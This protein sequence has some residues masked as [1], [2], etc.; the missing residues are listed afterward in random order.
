MNRS[1]HGITRRGC[2]RVTKID[3]ERSF[4]RWRGYPIARSI[5]N[6]KCV[7]LADLIEKGQPPTRV[8]MR[9]N[10]ET[11]FF[12]R[13]WRVLEQFDAVLGRQI[14]SPLSASE[15]SIERADWYA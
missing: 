4:N 14:R 10:T 3:N 5:D 8:A 7:L 9:T 15:E 11:A 13:A 2:E 12:G 1:P 6:F